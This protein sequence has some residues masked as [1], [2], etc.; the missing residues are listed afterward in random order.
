MCEAH[1][2]LGRLSHVKACHGETSEQM[3]RSLADAG[4]RQAV[5]AA[6]AKVRSDV[7]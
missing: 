7:S 2:T 1:V 6:M 3:M 5:E 4:A